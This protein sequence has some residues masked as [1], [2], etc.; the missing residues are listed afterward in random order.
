MPEG[1]E[2]PDDGAAPVVAAEEDGGGVR[3]DVVDEGGE[4]G[5]DFAVGV[6]LFPGQGLVCLGMLG[7]G[8]VGGACLSGVL[9][10]VGVAVAEHVGDDDAEV[11]GEEV[12]DLVAPAEGEVGVAVDEEDGADGGGRGA[13]EVVPFVTVERHGVVRDPGV[14]GDELVRGRRGGGHGDGDGGSDGGECCAGS[15]V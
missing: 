3:G 9:R 13:E 4:G 14:V 8:G 7:G 5:G 15:L 12:G 11:E 10:G 2:L 6:L 1:G